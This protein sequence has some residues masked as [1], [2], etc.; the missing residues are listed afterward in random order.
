[1]LGPVRKFAFAAA[2]SLALAQGAMGQEG[3]SQ[4]FYDL[5][6]QIYGHLNPTFQYVDDGVQ[7]YR[8]T[9]DN[10]NSVSRI[11]LRTTVK[12]EDGSEF[13]FNAET[14]FGFKTTSEVN[15]SIDVAEFQWRKTDIRKVEISYFTEAGTFW[16]GQGSMAT[17]GISESDY[18]GT[19]VAGYSGLQ[20]PAGLFGIR[21][22]TE[23]SGIPIGQVFRNYDGGRRFR[24]R[25]DS[26]VFSGF[27]FSGAAG[28][29]ILTDFR[30]TEYFDAAMRYRY[31]GEV[32]NVDAAIGYGWRDDFERAGTLSGSASFL[33]H[34]TGLNLTVAMAD[35][36]T[37]NGG[38]VYTKLGWRQTFWELGETALSF[39]RYQGTNITLP[40]G[41]SESFGIQAVQHIDRHNLA[42]YVGYRRYRY[43]DNKDTDYQDLSAV[44]AGARW[45]F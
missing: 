8:R 13:K 37:Q 31:N 1:M 18:S 45:K 5:R 39:D 36:L 38:Y 21:D 17:D 33:H 2:G 24:V 28:T 41:Q 27:Q 29:D 26:R 7:R 6:W 43:S 15:Q 9:A 32:F 10:A 34:E 11:G 40:N 25:Y 20:Y 44:L 16:F 35:V 12:L 42:L 22:G 30:D 14:A 19:R 3:T 4:R 23:L